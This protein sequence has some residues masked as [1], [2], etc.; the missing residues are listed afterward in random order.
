[1]VL[2][3]RGGGGTKGVTTSWRTQERWSWVGLKWKSLS[4]L[5]DNECHGT[6]AYLGKMFVDVC[7]CVCLQATGG[8]CLIHGILT[9]GHREVKL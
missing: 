7:V 3:W 9:Y 5:G 8:G 2:E 1:M 6:E 4:H